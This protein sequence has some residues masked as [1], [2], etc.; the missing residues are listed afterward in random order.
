MSESDSYLTIENISEGIYKDKGSKF[1]A[2]AFP[3]DDEAII[4]KRL[5]E[6]KKTYHDARHHCYAWRLGSSNQHYRVNDDGEPHNSAG[7]PIMSQIQSFNLT[8]ILVIVVRYFGGTLLGVPG[9][10]K[11]YK[12]ASSEALRNA[13]ITKKYEY[14]ILKINFDYKELSHVMKIIKDMNLEYFEQDFEQTCEVKVKV[15]S[16]YLSNFKSHFTLY[17]DIIIDEIING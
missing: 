9:L 16:S 2:F 6:I 11:A 12:I 17:P 1:M 4:K 14:R 8:N 3:A 10:V 7:N 15:R 5:E 13:K